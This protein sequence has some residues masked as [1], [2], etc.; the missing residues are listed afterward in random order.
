MVGFNKVRIK[1]KYMVVKMKIKKKGLFLPFPHPYE[2]VWI[3]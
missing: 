1:N 2:K 3:N